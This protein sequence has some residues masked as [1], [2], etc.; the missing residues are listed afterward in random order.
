MPPPGSQPPPRN[1]YAPPPQSGAPQSQYAP[2]PYGAPP[3]ATSR[4]PTGPPPSSGPP[5]AAR[6]QPTPPP[7]KAAAAPSKPRHPAGDRSHIPAHAQRLVDVLSSDMQRVASRAP[8]SF[9]AQVKDTQ[10]RLNLLF[11]H[12]NNEELIKPDTIDQLCALGEAIEQKNYEVA[13]KIQVEIQR[14]KT[15][16]CGNWMVGVKRLISMSK[17]TP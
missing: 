17:A 3:A 1:P 8:S 7:P 16:E 10:K 13:Q 15:D 2:S 6:A 11:D 9:G 4:P 5:P 12:L 14:D